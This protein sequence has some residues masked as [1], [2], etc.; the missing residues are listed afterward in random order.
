MQA[1][2]T[3]DR[4]AAL[5][6]P[7]PMPTDEARAE[8]N[9]CLMCWDAPCIRAWPTHIDIPLFIKQ[10]ASDDLLGSARTILDANI[11]G[12]ACGRVCPTEVLCE[13][14]CVL[15]DLHERPIEIGRL[16]TYATDPVVFGGV[17]AFT[18]TS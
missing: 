2:T 16:Q 6:P 11:L 1:T 4:W 7:P 13:G 15:H 18:P 10:I 5:E 12:S 17:P 9:R 8:A 14:A 3:T